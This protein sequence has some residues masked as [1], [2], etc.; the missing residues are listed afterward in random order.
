MKII[1]SGSI[2]RLPVGG[3]AWI[4]MQY[5][6]GLRSLGH[7][8][9]YLEECGE[10]SWVYNWETERLTTDLD[11]P[12]GYVADCLD[13]LGLGANWIYRAGEEWRGMPLEEFMEICSAADLMVVRA[14]PLPMW[15]PEYD[16]PRRRAFI[17]SD[18]G[19]TQISLIHGHADLT[20]TVER[21]DTLFTIGQR[22][23]EA[24]CIVP[25]VGREWFKTVAPVALDYWPVARTAPATHFTCVMQWRGFREV[26]FDGVLYGQKDKEFP[27]FIDLPRRT[28]QPL[29]LALTG[30]PSDLFSMHGWE[31]VEGWVASRTPHVYQE[32]IESSR[33]E[34]GVAKQGYVQMQSGW[35]SDR[36]VCYLASGRP[37]LL[38]D[39]GLSDWLPTDEGILSFS[40]VG[41]AV[42][43]IEVINAD[44][45]QHR[46]AARK[47]VEERFDAAKVL[48]SLLERAAG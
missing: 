9:Y 2:G 4:D 25:T 15:R 12:A 21:C 8:V 7:D 29:R 26:E 3:H 32:F 33:G 38:E 41:E 22:I 1:L 48:S 20:A 40:N 45:E 39:T 35:F 42:S 6:A 27:R 23:G 36:S 5:L 30:A 19:F 47:I 46:R 43:G 28:S 17:D 37:V 18:P 14:V 11:Y 31:V 13:L 16:F 24:G 44:Y 10:E 34:F